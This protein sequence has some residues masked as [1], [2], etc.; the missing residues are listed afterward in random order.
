MG[1]HLIPKLLQRG[2]SIVNLTTKRT[3]RETYDPKF[4]ESYWSP[5]EAK[6]DHIIF[7]KADAVINLAGFS[8]SNRWTKENRTRMIDSRIDSTG[9]LVSA[10]L[11]NQVPIQTFVSASASGFYSSSDVTQSEEE[12]KGTGF[13]PDLTADWENASTSLS[14][15]G[16]RRVIFRIG[17]VLAAE[18]GAL[19]K[20]LPFFKLGLGSAVGS[21]KQ[22]MS[23][24]HIE[25]LCEMFVFAVE[26][27]NLTGTYNAA[28]PYPVSNKDFSALLAQ[29]L[30]RPFIL[31][32]V[33]AFALKLAFGEMSSLL[34]ESRKLS[35]KK[36]ENAGYRFVYPE[37]S[38]ALKQLLTQK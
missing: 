6:I 28:T 2:H 34:L 23:W 4:M 12:I 7:D 33:P 18:D 19:V 38:G 26:S 17:V 5:K 32:K 27:K 8:V 20:M 22:W 31:P 24:I 3:I 21:G 13:L 14:H 36:I 30:K 1:S 9:L 15:N 35:S 29:T 11:D 16:I 10:I 37:L 25:D